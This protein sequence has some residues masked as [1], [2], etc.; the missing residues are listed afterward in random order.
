MVPNVLKEHCASSRDKQTVFFKTSETTHL[1][2]WYYISENLILIQDIVP[3]SMAT[4][5]YLTLLRLCPLI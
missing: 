2:T 3:E 4:V 5:S 1:I